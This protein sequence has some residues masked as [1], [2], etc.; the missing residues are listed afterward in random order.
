MQ[1]HGVQLT[2]FAATHVGKRRSCNEDAFLVADMMQTVP[3]EATICPVRVTV[4]GRGALLAVDLS[5]LFPRYGYP[6]DLL[7]RL[8]VAGARVVDVPVRPIYGP[9]WRSG[10]SLRTALYPVLFVVLRSLLWRLRARRRLSPTALARPAP[11]VSATPPASAA[12]Q[13]PT[14]QVMPAAAPDRL[15]P[16]DSADSADSAEP[17]LGPATERK[18]ALS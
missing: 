10:I 14:A 9:A 18:A 7:A 16:A 13:T 2:V 4:G 15:Q 17:A 1:A 11:P 5:A 8:W 6:N 12:P 3:L